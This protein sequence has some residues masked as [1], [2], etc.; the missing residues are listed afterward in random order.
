DQKINVLGI[1]FF[2][3]TASA[4]KRTVDFFWRN[5]LRH[6][7]HKNSGGSDSAANF[8]SVMKKRGCAKK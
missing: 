4:M 7:V 5:R 2:R 6:P 1:W 3:A 8:L